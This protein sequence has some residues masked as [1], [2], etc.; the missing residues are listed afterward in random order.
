MNILRRTFSTA[1]SFLCRDNTHHAADY[2]DSV[3][4]Q[5]FVIQVIANATRLIRDAFPTTTVI[6]VIGNH[7]YLP[8]NQLPPGVGQ[9]GSPDP[10]YSGIGDL[11]ATWIGSQ[12]EVD[13]FKAS[14]NDGVMTRKHFP[15]C[16]PFAR[17][18]RRCHGFPSQWTSSVSIWWVLC[19]RPDLWSHD[20]Y[21]VASFLWCSVS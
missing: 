14:K 12:P 21:V 16:W 11:W 1:F 3:F 2:S 9:G 4:S 10:I 19:Y 13:R 15:H 20:V 8:K 7:D 17:G 18:I 6:P 5:E